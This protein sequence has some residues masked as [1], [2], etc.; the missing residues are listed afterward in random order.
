MLNNDVVPQLLQIFE[1]Q[2]G[3]AFQ[4]LWWAQDG[5]P[6]HCLHAITAHLRE[7]FGHRVPALHHNVEW[8]PH[9]PDLTPCNFFLWGYLKE[10]SFH[11]PTQ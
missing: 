2:V 1:M 8:P 4:H 11:Q 3:G 10:Q 5:A 6:E 7:L 9:S